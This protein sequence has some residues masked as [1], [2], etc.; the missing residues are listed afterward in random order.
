MAR[1]EKCC[2]QLSEHIRKDKVS[3]CGL[4]NPIRSALKVVVLAT[5]KSFLYA[6]F[7]N[8]KQGIFKVKYANHY[9]LLFLQHLRSLAL[10]LV[11]S[12]NS[13]IKDQHRL[14]QYNNTFISFIKTTVTL[15]KYRGPMGISQNLTHTQMD[16]VHCKTKNIKIRYHKIVPR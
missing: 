5:D 3:L 7:Q 13:V 9:H 1:V 8:H 2:L 10:N 15:I 6:V 11:F 12:S 4:P 16:K 14:D